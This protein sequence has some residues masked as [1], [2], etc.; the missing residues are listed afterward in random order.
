MPRK[1]KKK[2]SKIEVS[3]PPLTDH[4]GLIIEDTTWTEELNL[5]RKTEKIGRHLSVIIIGIGA[6]LTILSLFTFVTQAN[7][8]FSNPLFIW[9]MNFFGVVNTLCGLLLLAKD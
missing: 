3:P 8:Q 5:F 7:F 2:L 4:R 9:T 6:T 1:R